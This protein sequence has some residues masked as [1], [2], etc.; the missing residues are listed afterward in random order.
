MT[1]QTINVGTAPNS[2]NGDPSRTAFTKINSN[3]TEL[4]NDVVSV[5]VLNYGADPTGIAD[6][7]P[8]FRAAAASNRVL[9]VPPGTYSFATSV[10]SPGSSFDNSCVLY[11]GLTNFSISAYGA[12]FVAAN[13]VALSSLFMFYNSSNVQFFGGIFIGSRSGLTSGQENVALTLLSVNNF[14]IVDCYV[15]SGFNSNGAG[16]AGDWLV[17]GVFEN[18]RMNN[19]GI[20]ADVAFLQN[21]TF[22][23]VV[24][25]GAGASGGVGAK[26]LSLIYDG[27]NVSNNL[28][29]VSFTVSNNISYVNC[30]MSNFQTGAAISTGAGISFQG[31]K[32]VGNVGGSGNPG[33]GVY[34]YYMNGGSFTSV[35]A[36]VQDVSFVGCTFRANGSV[37]LGTA[38]VVLDAA[39]SAG[40]DKITGIAFAGCTF[41]NNITQGIG[42]NSTVANLANL[43]AIGNTFTGSNQTI[44]IASNL[45]A[46]MNSIND[47]NQANISTALTLQAQVYHKNNV[48]NYWAD[49]SGNQQ[50]IMS[51]SPSNITY[52][53]PASAAAYIALQNFAGTNAMLVTNDA[54]NPI[55]IVVGG[56]LEQVLAGTASSGGAGYRQL[57]VPN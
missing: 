21:V 47:N 43:V 20:A 15:S 6:S 46:I 25:T 41:D 38:G 45:N 33:I 49:G 30:V 7:A 37:A 31:C 53:R 11:S 3:F 8:A 32:F 14:H 16:I 42:V 22:L 1:Q 34:L 24:A 55:Q 36:P 13:S 9:L 39:T 57:I 26:G 2:G 40:T 17:N 27:P 18:I 28:T 23:N 4:Y 29:G 48:A 35:G 12:T 44:S 5:S 56:V 52:L 51:V 50:P 19:V 10:A 54:N